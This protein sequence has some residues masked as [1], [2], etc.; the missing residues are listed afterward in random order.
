M[1]L[2]AQAVTF[3]RPV[4]EMLT[5][6]PGPLTAMERYLWTRYNLAQARIHQQYSSAR[7]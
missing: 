6:M 2:F 7:R 3:G 1:K 4:R 5:G